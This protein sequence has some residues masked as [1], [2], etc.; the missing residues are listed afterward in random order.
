MR[1][2]ELIQR[3][4]KDLENI[5]HGMEDEDLL[6]G[7]EH[8]KVFLPNSDRSYIIFRKPNMEICAHYLEELANQRSWR[9]AMKTLFKETLV[10][11]HLESKDG[12]ILLHAN[13][14]E[15]KNIADI[16][17]KRVAPAIAMWA[18]FTILST[19][20]KALPLMGVPNAIP[21]ENQIEEIK[22]E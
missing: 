17:M 7:D 8:S 13:V 4:L 16:M 18:S 3:Q 1:I 2:D 9:E 14:N 21:E 5:V 6:L 10:E 12:R 22:V 15:N 20:S 11:I 19:V